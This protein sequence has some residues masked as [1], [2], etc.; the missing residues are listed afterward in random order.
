[1]FTD[2]ITPDLIAAAAEAA[3]NLITKHSGERHYV[4]TRETAPAWVGDLAREAH[5]GMLPDDWRYAKI[6]DACAAIAGAGAGEDLSELS[7]RHSDDAVS[8]YTGERTAWLATNITR[9]G[10]CDAGAEESGAPGP[11][12]M[13]DLLAMGQYAEAH[14]IFAIV[15]SELLKH[16]G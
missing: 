11:I 3:Y 14:E 13:V 2:T 9:V 10:Y 6:A 7:F 5:D 16:I 12:A 15:V 8:I 1:M 4:T